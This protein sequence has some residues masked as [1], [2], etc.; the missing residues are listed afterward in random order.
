MGYRQNTKT[1]EWW[2]VDA[3]GNPIRPVSSTPQPN[4]DPL[5][6]GP[7]ARAN[8]GKTIADTQGQAIDNSVKGA[9]APS[10]IAKAA[11]DADKAGSEAI[12]SAAETRLNGLPAE[13]YKKA[14]D[15]FNGARML[16]GIA[17][18]LQGKFD[19]G[20]GM[21]SGLAGGIE[22]FLPLPRNQRFNKAADSARGQIVTALGLIGSAVNSPG[23]AQLWTGPYIPSSWDYDQTITDSIG[24]LNN[25]RENAARTAIMTLGGVPDTTGKVWPLGS[26]E[27]EREL[28]G[29]GMSSSQFGAVTVPSGTVGGPGAPPAG[30]GPNGAPPTPW[31]A[32]DNSA[33]GTSSL[34]KGDSKFIFDGETSR[35]VDSLIGA[36]RPF[37]E[38]DAYVRARGYPQGLNPKNY[39]EWVKY[40]KTHPN[41]MSTNIGREEPISYGE[42]FKRSP[43]AAGALGASNAMTLGLNDELLAGGMSLL[44]QGD[45]GQLLDRYNADKTI[46]ASENPKSDMFGNIAGGFLGGYGLGRLAPGLGSAA[47]KAPLATAGLYGAAYGA[48]QENN[49]RLGGAILG[50]ATGLGGGAVGKYAIAPALDKAANSALGQTLTDA[51]NRYR[52]GTA[53]LPSVVGPQDMAMIKAKPDFARAS[54]NLRD[55]ADMGLPYTIADADPRLRILG[56]VISRKSPNARALAEDTFGPRAQGQVDR[57]TS[58]VNDYLA[59]PAD[60]AARGS[61]ILDAADVAAGPYYRQAFNRPGPVDDTLAAM[62]ETPAGKSALGHARTIAG[63]KQIDPNKIG[64]DLNDLGE[65]TLTSVPSYETL[66]L[67][68]RGM[69]QTINDYADPLGRVSARGNP[70]L[71]SVIG[72]KDRFNSRLGEIN[73]LYAQGNAEWSKFARAKDALDAGFSELPKS[74]MNQN[75]FDR[76]VGGLDDVTLPEARIGY[77][78]AMTDKAAKMRYSGNPYNAAYGSPLERGKVASLFPSGAP[79]FDRLAGLEGDMAKTAYETLGG[80]PTA[81]RV[82]MDEAMSG[83]L[84]GVAGVAGD[85]ATGGKL[86]LLQSMTRLLGRGA[87]NGLS[88]GANKLAEKN[89]ENLAPVLFNPRSP[90][91]AAAALEDVQVRYNELLRRRGRMGLF[92]GLLAP[93]I[94]PV[95]GR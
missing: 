88:R 70:L 63:N 38:A 87:S 50:A 6:K 67:V 27:A 36:G 10:V 40:K 26:P 57:F 46:A 22:D 79:K 85:L 1:G 82:G 62:L 49:N 34:A 54:A 55:A 17:G 39:S 94:A 51:I 12:K 68:K 53:S 92:G 58:G 95:G 72:L 31:D 2:E 13:T 89:A 66:Q 33:I 14:I 25:I 69:D 45:Y 3:Q 30:A 76:Y 47:A 19:E 93:A 44:G 18:D 84:A 83:P 52:P 4:N 24:R 8:V 74:S 64:I 60:I 75:A 59:E 78:T 20:P 86:G 15:Q 7:T 42:A 77:A 65:P 81:A 5:M 71:Q 73:P 28:S 32:P 91:E 23:E 61:N 16:G 80:S 37:A 11:K 43:V 35:G 21:T 56:G 9:T 29:L 41:S 90:A 48:G